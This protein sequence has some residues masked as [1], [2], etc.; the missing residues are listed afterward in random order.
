MLPFFKY[1]VCFVFCFNIT[2]VNAAEVIADFDEVLPAELEAFGRADL[3]D[4]T[5]MQSILYGEDTNE[6]GRIILLGKYFDAKYPNDLIN[7]D[8]SDDVAAIFPELSQQEVYDRTNYIRHAVNLYRWG[9]NKYNDIKA[10]EER[11]W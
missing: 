1:I 5:Q 10:K 11:K 4:A 7:N 2:A 3:P 9:T 6:L 8:F